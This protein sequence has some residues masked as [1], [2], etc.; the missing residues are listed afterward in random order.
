MSKQNRIYME[1]R[2]EGYFL[3]FAWMVVGLLMVGLHI[4]IMGIAVADDDPQW[5]RTRDH[6][7][8]LGGS[9][10]S[11]EF[12][13]GQLSLQRGENEPSV[14][15][16]KKDYENFEV[17]FEFLLSRWCESGIFFHAPRNGAMQAG[18]EVSLSS[19]TYM[20]PGTFVA[21]SIAGVESPL[22]IVEQSPF[23]WHKFEATLDWPKFTVKINNV[24]VQDIDLA[25]HP[26]L[27]HKLRSGAFG[28]QNNG[29]AA[30]FRD[31]KITPLQGAQ[32][33]QELF[34]GK[35]LN[36]WTVVAGDAKWV[37]KEGVLI[38]QNGDGYLMH[39]D[40]FDDFR[41]RMYIRTTP[42][43]NGGVFF[44]WV[45][46][47]PEERG[48]EVQILDVPYTDVPTGSVYGLSRG[49]DL[50]LSPGEW[51]LLQINVKGREVRTFV[52]G[53][54]AAEYT[55]LDWLHPG[56]IVLQMHRT[57]ATIEFKD[58]VVESY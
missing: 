50:A 15:L 37:V 33:Q 16:S 20:K 11:F 57:R 52:N 35:D 48:Y 51:E 30:A 7:I 44:R 13:G 43:A 41:L 40:S 19:R 21:G 3:N 45:S 12:A 10:T 18:M 26:A 22:K 54:P 4:F 24:V 34:N 55:E 9:E 28:I 29:Y 47:D 58:I 31:I 14:L 6:W 53:I 2:S 23:E 56:H 42:I 27:Q 49:S 1:V 5:S 39:K 46:T 36:G 17:S 32:K 8:Q 38:G 25:L